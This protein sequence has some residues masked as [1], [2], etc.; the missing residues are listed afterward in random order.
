MWP[1]RSVYT[2]KSLSPTNENGYNVAVAELAGMFVV[3]N[4]DIAER[5]VRNR[6]VFGALE[7]EKLPAEVV[8]RLIVE[9]HG[10]TTM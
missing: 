10:N 4:D 2:T 8:D 5:L 6:N 9:L 1:R 3:A 7:R